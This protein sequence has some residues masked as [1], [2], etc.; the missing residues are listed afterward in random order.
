MLGGC[1][2][3][4]GL[5]TRRRKIKGYWPFEVQFLKARINGYI[6]VLMQPI[7][8]KILPSRKRKEIM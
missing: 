5:R 6:A 7:G 8:L 4:F 2:S 3:R 1:L